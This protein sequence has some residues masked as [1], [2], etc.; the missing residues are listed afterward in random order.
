MMS[1]IWPLSAVPTAGILHLATVDGKDAS[2]RASGTQ[3]V[4]NVGA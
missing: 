4:Q 1:G 3:V 2:R